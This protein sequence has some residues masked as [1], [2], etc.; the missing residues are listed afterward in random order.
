MLQHVMSEPVKKTDYALCCTIVTNILFF[1]PIETL[2]QSLLQQMV[3]LATMPWMSGEVKLQDLRIGDTLT[4]NMVKV[5]STLRDD[6][7][8]DPLL[9][10]VTL[11]STPPKEVSPKWRL[12]VIRKAFSE[13]EVILRR[14]IISQMP[15][16][17]HNI[18][19]SSHPLAKEIISEA[20]AS[21]EKSVLLD[22]AKISGSLL[23]LFA[24]TTSLSKKQAN[25]EIFCSRCHGNRQ[26]TG[27]DSDRMIPYQDVGD[28]FKLIGNND[29]DIKVAI[30]SLLRPMS[31]HVGVNET[32]VNLWIKYIEEM[33]DSPTL[34]FAIDIKVLFAPAVSLKQKPPTPTHPEEDPPPLKSSSHLVGWEAQDAVAKIL[35]QSLSDLCDR[36]KATRSVEFLDTLCRSLV[37]VGSSRAP[38]VEEECTKLLMELIYS[39]ITHVVTFNHAESFLRTKIAKY[40]SSMMIRLAEKM[41]ASGSNPNVPL[42]FFMALFKSGHI[43]R[44]LNQYL[45]YLLPHLV[46]LSATK[47]IDGPQ[48][49]L[50]HLSSAMEMRS[51]HLIV[52]NFQYIFPYVVMHTENSS[53]YSV[54]MKYIEMK[55]KVPLHH[56]LPSNRQKVINELLSCFHS[57]NR[58]VITA[59]Q[60]LAKNDEDFELKGRPG[61]L[62]KSDIVAYILPKLLGILGYFDQKMN[63]EMVV[64]ESKVAILESLH[65][66]VLFMGSDAIST[67]KHK[68]V[69]TLRTASNV[70]SK[71]SKLLLSILCRTW[72]AFLATMD[73]SS[74]API[75]SQVCANLWNIFELGCTDVVSL[76][77]FLIIEHQTDLKDQFRFLHFI[78]EVMELVEI[79]SLIRKHC[80]IDENTKF[81]EIIN[82]L[83]I[84]LKNETAEVKALALKKLRHLFRMNQGRLQGLI[85][86][87]DLVDPMISRVIESLIQC[88]QDSD[89]VIV[90]FAGQCLGLIGAL[91]PGRLERPDDL[92]GNMNISFSVFDEDF[93]YDLL[94]A[95][96]KAFLTAAD[97][98]DSDACAFTLQEVLRAYKITGPAP[99]A[100]MG[101][102]IWNRCSDSQ[103]ELLTPLLSSLYSRSH[104]DSSFLVPIYKSRENMTYLDW[105]SDW[106][107]HLIGKVQDEKTRKVLTG[108]KAALKKDLQTAQFL[109]PY[110]VVTVVCQ[111]NAK[112]T[113][114]I[115]L[116]VETVIN[117][118]ESS[119]SSKSSPTVSLAS[120]S[121]SKGRMA[122]KEFERLASQTIFAI[123]DHMNRWLRKKYRVMSA[124]MK[125]SETAEKVKAKDK[126]YM[127]I[128]KLIQSIPQKTLA[129]A[130]FSCK[131]Y[132]RSLMH[133]E[134]HI[135]QNPE[136]L[137]TLFNTLQRVYGSLQETDYVRG[138]AAMRLKDPPLK[139]LIH[140]HEAIGNYS[141]AL[142]CYESIGK[143]GEKG[144]DLIKGML[145]CYLEIDRPHT[146]SI[147]IEGLLE[148]KNKDESDDPEFTE[149]LHKYQLEASW[150]L[151]QWDKVES[152]VSFQTAEGE[153]APSKEI[154]ETGLVK[155]L[156][157]LYSEDR[158]NFYKQLE[159]STN[160]EM[161][162]ITASAME[163][164]AFGRS[165]EHVVRLQMLNEIETIGELAFFNREQSPP[166]IEQLSDLFASWKTRTSYAQYSAGHLESVLKVRRAVLDIASSRFKNSTNIHDLLS[167]QLG[168]FWL[169]SAKVARKSGQLQ[170]S[171]NLLLE[172]EKFSG[173]ELFIE[174]SKLF[175]ARGNQ[176][177]AISILR[178][179]IADKFPWYKPEF[180]K[181]RI[182]KSELRVCGNAKLQMARYID[183][184]ANLEAGSVPIFYNEAR[185]LSGPS[186]DNFYYCAKFFDKV[187]G[188]DYKT[189]DLDMKGDIIFHIIGSYVR[190]LMYGCT[191][192]LQSLPRLLSLWFD[193]GSRVVTKVNSKAASNTT[194]TR[195]D[196]IGSIKKMNDIIIKF[197]ERCPVF[198]FLAVFPQLT[199]RI[200]HSH[201]EV[202]RILKDIMVKSFIKFPSQCF[203]HMVALSKSSHEI[204]RS[205]CKEVFNLA[206]QKRP[207]LRPLIEDGLKLADVLQMLSDE[208]IGPGAAS[209]TQVMPSLPKL[210]SKKNFSAIMIP[211]TRN[212]SIVMPSAEG[213]KFNHSPFLSER[214]PHFFRVEDEITVMR[215]LVTPKKVT[216][217]GSDG[218]KY[219]FLCKPKDD[220]RRDCRLIDF[221]ILL[222]KLF[223]KDP[224]C[225]KRDLRIRT[226]VRIKAYHKK[227]RFPSS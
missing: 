214:P 58:R 100:T 105:L 212:M 120:S 125:R 121:S 5:S 31:N 126:E 213:D 149:M 54:C 29:D 11:M 226:Y 151:S 119:S 12:R 92:S 36:A 2:T 173:M 33:E 210:L 198:Y 187:I 6:M 57:H 217:I 97:S 132:A 35:L 32:T 171:Y 65:D 192:I 19:F 205:R 8:R 183:E 13:D 21:N 84:P 101:G 7:D 76:F 85:V 200:C 39:P 15:I 188:K 40:K 155:L 17:M 189:E 47:N 71:E 91:D 180:D 28:L 209:L 69:S 191:N 156:C 138:I 143:T 88:S 70:K 44:L 227:F 30:L 178:K 53:E 174:R 9:Q 172:S 204:R 144:V 72:K 95:L 124:S 175:W 90:N 108:C 93:I 224:E 75:L 74:I 117:A 107:H 160:S 201:E 112:D 68:I 215:S 177:E 63:N 52:E 115:V 81:K 208:R 207:D 62:T 137:Q 37:N 179:G 38:N 129:L 41:C 163:E 136:E 10:S 60:W 157:C 146:A 46:L 118:D 194:K 199:S 223:M 139:E 181:K 166:S 142:S 216:F 79:N 80:G 3:A 110:L 64:Y 22:L 114:E 164:G 130:S 50:E 134:S 51:K 185:A 109:I 186:E 165:Y 195:N 116:E 82:V 113:D 61:K 67:V 154:W 98:H 167:K 184:A 218:S 1:Q 176:E 55:T 161:P 66:L 131:S 77:K 14:M 59:F 182:D 211:T 89:P 18:G 73:I 220:L 45:H 83:I 219:P 49:P 106:C 133:W 140:Y 99:I 27:S 123:L 221:N 193:Y 222:N 168:E 141:D 87:N 4:H 162:A 153:D 159:I 225:R 197:H 103:Q 169:L 102:K 145:R 152:S 23:C 104:K 122:S 190:S 78:P 56:L 96:S 203:W 26:L 16:W 24:K 128:D 34:K 170:K 94:R 42:E 127:A 202:W 25:Y 158:M 135:R 206:I 43:R 150:Q 147:L 111:D 196:M 48:S 148:E 86:T 20:L